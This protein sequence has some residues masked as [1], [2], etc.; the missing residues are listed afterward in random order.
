MKKMSAMDKAVEYA[1][2]VGTAHV[3]LE[4][5]LLD[6]NR[7]NTPWLKQEIKTWLKKSEELGKCQNSESES[8]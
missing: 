1:K 6:K 4:T 5:V 2:L 7:A 8:N 3:L